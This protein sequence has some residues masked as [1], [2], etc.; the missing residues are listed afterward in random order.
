MVLVE[1]AEAI[2][3]RRSV[4]AF[5]NRRVSNAVVEQLLD[6]ARYAP[7]SMNGQPWHFIVVRRPALKRALAKTKNRYCPEEKAAYR[8]DFIQKADVLIVCVERTK[9]HGRD[10]ENAV[11]AAAM[12]MLAA[13]A[14][15]LA[16]VYMSAY[17]RAKPQLA[18]EISMLLGLP[19]KIIPVT[20][21]PFG[22]PSRKPATKELR[23]LKEMIHHEH[24]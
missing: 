19:R 13:Q 18:R 7:S 14:R 9:S 2:R 24:F 10:V 5:Q 15:G 8:A 12:F 17:Q 22:Y 16:S 21:I 3:R 1:L 11:L 6:L 20:I 4:R 23:D